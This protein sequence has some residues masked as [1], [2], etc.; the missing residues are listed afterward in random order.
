M[1]VALLCYRNSRTRP[2]ARCF[3]GC[4]GRD[5]AVHCPVPVHLQKAYAHLGYKPGDL[6][7]TER[8][9]RLRRFAEFKYTEYLS[10]T[11]RGGEIEDATEARIAASARTG[12]A[13]IRKSK[14]SS[15]TIG[16][17]RRISH[18]PCLKGALVH[19]SQATTAIAI[20]N[21]TST[22]SHT[23]RRCFRPA[24]RSVTKL[25]IWSRPKPARK[26]TAIKKRT[27]AVL[28]PGCY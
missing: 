9:S 5:G 14:P 18:P 23:R 19:N 4:R 22:G 13:L 7:L 1:R 21:I 11:V 28:L 15:T 8:I 20:R 12:V 17:R 27:N 10:S 24:P 25:P 6:P 3:A 16:A 2:G 26:T